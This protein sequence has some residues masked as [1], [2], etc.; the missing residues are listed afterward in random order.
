[1]VR[2]RARAAS[3]T[4]AQTSQGPFA[5]DVSAAFAS[6]TTARGWWR[7]VVH[8]A[9][10]HC[11]ARVLAAGSGGGVKL[12]PSG[13][14]MLTL[15]GAP[16]KVARYRVSGQATSPGQNVPV[17]LDVLLVT[18]GRFVTELQLSNF[19]APPPNQLE[20]R[21]ARLLARRLGSA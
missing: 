11:F 21:L 10:S 2:P 18:R 14:R 9:L 13:T 7:Q 19:D 6:A 12:K 3:A 20:L 16:P 8:P 15:A 4:F 5:F 1:V 17:Y